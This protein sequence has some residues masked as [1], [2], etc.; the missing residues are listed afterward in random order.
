MFAIFN[1]FQIVLL[2]AC[3][4]FIIQY[5]NTAEF[6]G[7]AILFWTLLVGYLVGFWAMCACVYKTALDK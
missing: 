3:A 4:P 2:F 6:S 7:H 1:S 5:V